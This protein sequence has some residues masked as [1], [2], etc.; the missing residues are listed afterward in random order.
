M[1]QLKNGG[2]ATGYIFLKLGETTLVI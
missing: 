2:F 1:E